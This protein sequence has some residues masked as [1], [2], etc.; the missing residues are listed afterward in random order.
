MSK[1]Y[2][3]LWKRVTPILLISLLLS[4]SITCRR[5]EPVIYPI[6]TNNMVVRM[7]ENGNYEV[8]PGFVHNYFKLIAENVVLKLKIKKFEDRE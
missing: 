3:R 4:I 5:P 7:L 2:S 1:G 8:K 6:D